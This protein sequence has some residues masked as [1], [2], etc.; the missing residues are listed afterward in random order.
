M[1]QPPIPPRHQ[2]LMSASPRGG[3]RQFYGWTPM[4]A[5]ADGGSVQR[6]VEK[7]LIFFC[8][9]RRWVPAVGCVVVE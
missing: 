4:C 7:E 3:A 1:V 6:G 9:G 2:R 5:A 8:S